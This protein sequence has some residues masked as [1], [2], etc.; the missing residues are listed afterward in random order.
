MPEQARDQ[1][2]I[3]YSHRDKK[4]LE[5]LRTA[6]MPLVHQ[7]TINVW[8]DTQIKPGAKWKDEIER[9]LAS[10]KVAVLLVS[11]NFLASEFIVERELASLLEAAEQQGATI[12]WV[13]V[14]ASLYEETEI[15]KYQA[16]NDPSRPLDGL[17]GAD[18]N[19]ELVS[20]ARKIKA[21]AN[22]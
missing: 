4:W 14:S 3:S 2:F 12:I 17:K 5:R 19:K 15:A 21:A 9:A 10:A 11:Q 1:V 18:L 16:A 6:L 13:A 8:A 20:I 7:G 22:P